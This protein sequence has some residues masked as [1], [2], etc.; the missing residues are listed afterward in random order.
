MKLKISAFLFVA[1][2]AT[3][4]HSS[5]LLLGNFG[6]E[7]TGKKGETVWSIRATG[8]SYELFSLG[9]NFKT[10]LQPLSKAAVAALWKELLW[11]QATTAGVVCLGNDEDI[12][13]H[14]PQNQR[15]K[16]D[17]LAGNKSNYFFYSA[18]GG[19]MEIK[20]LSP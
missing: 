14:V 16:I 8:S 13:C 6:H 4:A 3:S 1:L 17:W 19:V 20:R 10:G 9:G 11:P 2:C 15:K 12:F 7:F 5:E 18:M